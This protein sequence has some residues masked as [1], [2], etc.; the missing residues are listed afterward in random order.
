MIR[1]FPTKAA[2]LTLILLIV[3]SCY[4]PL[5]WFDGPRPEGQPMP[6]PIVLATHTPTPTPTPTP[7]PSCP[8]GDA[9]DYLS[10]V[11][12]T[13]YGHGEE[14]GDFRNMVRVVGA[15]CED[16]AAEWVPV[17]EKSVRASLPEVKELIASGQKLKES[18]PKQYT[19]E[20]QAIESLG[21]EDLY[22]AVLAMYL[23]FPAHT[24]MQNLVYLGRRAGSCLNPSNCKPL[25]T[26]SCV[27]AFEI[28]RDG[29]L[30]EFMKE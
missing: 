21:D 10:C 22:R 8:T 20:G 24:G 11:K 26:G 19:L 27:R 25:Q 18:L 30:I 9:Y 6:P 23:S 2:G 13:F 29:H 1:R 12:P 7:M 16:D 15:Y 3:S 5:D 28:I 14:P 17:L 4:G